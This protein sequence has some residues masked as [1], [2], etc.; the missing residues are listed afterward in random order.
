MQSG[1]MMVI[2]DHSSINPE[3]IAAK[4]RVVGLA[5][6]G[7]KL[8]EVCDINDV[9]DSILLF[10]TLANI[11]SFCRRKCYVLEK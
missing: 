9:H 6:W 2:E 11:A 3:L 7:R 5:I 10:W 4:D 1:N 8:A